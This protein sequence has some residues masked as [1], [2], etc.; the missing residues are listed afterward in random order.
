MIA[1]SLT[2]SFPHDIALA[3]LLVTVA[4]LIADH[5]GDQVAAG[6]PSRLSTAP[7]PN[8]T[9][10]LRGRTPVPT[11]PSPAAPTVYDQEADSGSR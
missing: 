8:P 9:R 3:I 1:F 10:M 4:I 6:E 11:R 2:G 7:G 5:F